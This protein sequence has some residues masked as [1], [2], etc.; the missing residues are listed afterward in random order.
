MPIESPL[1]VVE[2]TAKLAPSSWIFSFFKFGWKSMEDGSQ[3]VSASDQQQSFQAALH[4]Y[5]RILLVLKVIGVYV[6]DSTEN[7]AKSKRIDILQRC[8][9]GICCLFYCSLALL[10][11][12]R[13]LIISGTKLEIMGG[14][15]VSAINFNVPAIVFCQFCNGS[16]FAQLIQHWTLLQKTR[17]YHGYPLFSRLIKI[18]IGVAVLI[19]IFPLCNFLAVTWGLQNKDT[20]HHLSPFQFSNMTAGDESVTL[21]AGLSAIYICMSSFLSL[22]IWTIIVI[23]AYVIKTDFNFACHALNEAIQSIAL[24]GSS[25]KHRS[26]QNIHTGCNGQEEGHIKKTGDAV[27]CTAIGAPT[28]GNDVGDIEDARLYHDDACGLL[29]KADAIF[30]PV[31]GIILAL[32]LFMTSVGLYQVAYGTS[33]EDTGFLFSMMSA[34]PIIVST[35]T[36]ASCVIASCVLVNK[37]VSKPLNPAIS[38]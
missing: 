21:E 33:T 14:L 36:V 30:S 7:S 3:P 29:E 23:T 35:L 17:G 13:Q 26:T 11:V 32:N 34:L 18:Y 15:M 25:R 16:G 9:S 27:R 2:P 38:E 10:V 12:Y 24:H 5:K 1:L 8:Y 31:L 28:T 19:M 22:T 4:I 37:S 6:N 20:L